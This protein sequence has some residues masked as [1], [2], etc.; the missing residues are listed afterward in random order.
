[1]IWT[2]EEIEFFGDTGAVFL[3]SGRGEHDQMHFVDH[4]KRKIPIRS[5]R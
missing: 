5:R 4:N 2:I 1:M 3:A